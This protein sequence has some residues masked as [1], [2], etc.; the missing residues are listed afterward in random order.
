MARTNPAN[1]NYYFIIRLF[2][3]KQRVVDDDELGSQNS[4]RSVFFANPIHV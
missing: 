1:S 3:I 2:A 4:K